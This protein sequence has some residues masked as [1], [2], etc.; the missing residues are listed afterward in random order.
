MK[1]KLGFGILNT[2]MNGEYDG[3]E[4]DSFEEAER[5]QYGDD[6]HHLD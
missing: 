5:E 2:E 3:V 6:F 1:F 4:Y